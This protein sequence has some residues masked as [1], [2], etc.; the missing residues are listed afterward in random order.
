M[1]LKDL[2]PQEFA[3]QENAFNLIKY[4]LTDEFTKMQLTKKKSPIVLKGIKF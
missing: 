2:L 4:I 3:Q 1:I